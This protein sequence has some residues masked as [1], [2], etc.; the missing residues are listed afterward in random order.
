M[1]KTESDR[2]AGG[3]PEGMPPRYRVYDI[4]ALVYDASGNVIGEWTDTQELWLEPPTIAVRRTRQLPDGSTVVYEDRGQL[5]PDFQISGDDGFG[6]AWSGRPLPQD[7]MLFTQGTGPTASFYMTNWVLEP[8]E[9]R[10]LRVI[11]VHEPVAFLTETE[12]QPGRYYVRTRD[13]LR[14]ASD[15]VPD[16][17]K[18]P[19]S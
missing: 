9:E 4:D 17:M 5:G 1:A 13:H 3:G 19:A 15:D 8:G 10:C 11:D 14:S 16:A 2:R 6:G 18:R 12:L 7:G